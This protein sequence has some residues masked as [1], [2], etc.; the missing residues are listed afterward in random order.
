MN[1]VFERILKHYGLNIHKL[2]SMERQ[3]KATAKSF[4]YVEIYLDNVKVSKSQRLYFQCSIYF[5]YPHPCGVAMQTAVHFREFTPFDFANCHI[6]NI[7]Q[8]YNN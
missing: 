4:L 1:K 7:N 3:I 5:I 6:I 8:L 2:R